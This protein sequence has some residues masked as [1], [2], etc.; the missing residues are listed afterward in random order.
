MLLFKLSFLA[1]IKDCLS[2]C[3]K[4]FLSF[5]KVAW[6]VVNSEAWNDIKKIKIT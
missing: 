4:S 5:S 1:F 6:Q 3:L 2:P